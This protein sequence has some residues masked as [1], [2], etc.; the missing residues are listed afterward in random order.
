MKVNVLKIGISTHSGKQIWSE[1]RYG[2]DIKLQIDRQF[3]T[4]FAIVVDIAIAKIQANVESEATGRVQV[5]F[6][7][8]VISGYIMIIAPNT[9]AI[10]VGAFQAVEAHACRK[11]K[12]HLSIGSSRCYHCHKQRNP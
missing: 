11:S 2:I 8:E 6:Y 5:G 12:F 10:V 4:P 3:H 7:A 9:C 1:H